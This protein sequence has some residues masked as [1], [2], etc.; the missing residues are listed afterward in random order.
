MEK[1]PAYVVTNESI[2]INWEG[3]PY[4]VKKGTPNYAP[5]KDAIY[6]EEWDN[7][8]NFLTAGKGLEEYVKGKFTLVAD[9]FHYE[10]EAV[11][12]DMNRR[13]IDLANEGQD[14]TPIFNF[15]ERLK[16]NP[17][18]RSVKQLWSFLNH[19]GIPLTDDGC[20]LAYKGVK[21]N[22]KDCHTGTYDNRP[23]AKHEMDRNK[24]SD[25]PSTP[26]HEGFHVGAKEYATSFGPITVICKV[27]PENVV[28]VPYDSSAQKMRVCKYEVIGNYGAELP[29]T[30]MPNK[31]IGVPSSSYPSCAGNDSE[32]EE[33]E[34]DLPEDD[35]DEGVEDNEDV[36]ED[37]DDD[38]ED[39]IEGDEGGV[40]STAP[41]FG[42]DVTDVVADTKLVRGFAKF[43]RMGMR[44][45]MDQSIEELRKYAANGLK[46]VGASKIPGGK[47]ALVGRIMKV[48][49]KL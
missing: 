24:V 11:P 21:E 39:E 34:D 23:G 40:L 15:Y 44:E 30:L 5:L 41:D 29:D 17:S 26:C 42:S 43:S 2:S 36:E 31:D 10:G 28:C 12:D 25:D 4:V 47:T 49:E 19:K 16:K 13:I 46:I 8:P 22:Y 14:P 45:L 38:D 37:L 27:D 35:L 32:E 7:V 6:F 48:R 33:D 9:K 3:K 18:Y 1:T 20:F